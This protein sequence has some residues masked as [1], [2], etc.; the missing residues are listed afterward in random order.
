MKFGIAWQFFIKIPDTK[1]HEN[2]FSRSRVV[3]CVQADRQTDR[4]TDWTKLKGAFSQKRLRTRLKISF[5]I[6]FILPPLGLCLPGRPHQS[7]PL[8]PPPPPP[9]TSLIWGMNILSFILFS[10]CVRVARCVL[11]I[12]SGYNTR[13][14]LCLCAGGKCLTIIYKLFNVLALKPLENLLCI[15]KVFK[16]WDLIEVSVIE[17]YFYSNFYRSQQSSWLVAF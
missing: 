6:F 8:P 17:T 5:K 2:R 15:F 4:Q 9:A 1:F 7:S 11:Y 14:C 12:I 13:H 16:S 3:S 10:V